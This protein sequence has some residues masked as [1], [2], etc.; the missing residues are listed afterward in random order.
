[1]HVTRIA[2]C[3]LALAGAT[4]CTQ[5]KST[6]LP[7]EDGVT[8]HGPC[9]SILFAP[10][11][12]T[13]TH[14]TQCSY[15]EYA[16]NPPS[17]GPHYAVW[18][19]FREYDKPFA[20]GFWVHSLEHSAAVLLWGCDKNDPACA[21]MIGEAR[22]WMAAREQDPLCTPPIRSRVLMLPYPQLGRAFAAVLWGHYL[23][24]DCFDAALVDQLVATY[25][26]ENYEN[27]CS[28]GLDPTTVPVK[29]CGEKP[30]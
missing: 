9:D 19:D 15:V 14:V 1:V 26:G 5:K 21:K 28:P 12:P 3:V 2:A 4:G 16:T 11:A 25:Y 18:A 7:A 10:D 24:A 8:K 23:T 20:P 30:P 27:L 17:F 22:A 13:G 29:G 6:G